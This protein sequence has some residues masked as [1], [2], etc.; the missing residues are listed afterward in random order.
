LEITLPNSW[1]PRPYQR[2]L[3]NYLESGGRR[4]IAVWHRRAGKDDVGLH[5]VAVAAHERIGGYWHLLP[6]ATQARK[7][8]WNAV[9]PHT[10]FRRIDEA[11]PAA[12]RETTLENEMLIRFKSGSTYQLAGS[13]NYNSLVGSTPVGVIFSE[14]ALA[15]PGAWGFIRPMLLENNGWAY[16]PYT[17]RGRNHGATFFDGHKGDKNWFVE[18]LSADQTG[19]FTAEQLASERAEL[20][21]EYGQEDGD[22]RFRQE[23]MCSFEAGVPGAYYGRG[24]EDAE[25]DGRI[26][27][28]PWIANLPVHTGWDLGRRD[29]TTIWFFQLPAGNRGPVHFID[30]VENNGVDITWY[31]KE[32]DKKP[33]KFGRLALPHDAYSEHLAADKTIAGTLQALGYR[34]QHKVERT[35]NI[36][37]D[38]NA[39]R[40]IL[41]RCRFDAEKCERGINALRNYR[42]AWDEKRKVYHDR[43]L[44]DWASHG[45]DGFRTA[46]MA[47]ADGLD[48][49]GAPKKIVYPKLGIV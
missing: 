21:K 33:Y 14:W 13:D 20:I 6:E 1:Q 16:F 34:D 41:P 44:H 26:C 19:V 32:L 17:P 47:I 7:V 35:T 40:M 5:R 2:A 45:A 22:N 4:A 3:W 10:G 9:N 30:Y 25:K 43:P 37:Q 48:N 23:Y 12:L 8:I 28:V 36:D 46:A 27:A 11:F 15:D 38:I 31:A 42:K 18:K 29:L 24:M 49:P 39:G